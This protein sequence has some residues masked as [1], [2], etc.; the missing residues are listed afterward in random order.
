MTDNRGMT[1]TFV[2]LGANL[3]DPRAQ[4][5]RALEL[6]AEEDGVE[7]VAVSTLRETDP[8]GYED[9]PRFLNGAAELRTTLGARE[10]LER[11]LEI[12]RRMGRVRGE[13]PR[14]GP[15]TIDLDLL[16]YGDEV[17]D[18]PGLEI[19]HPRLH[20]RAFA[21]EPLAELD[22][23]LEIPGRGPVQTLLAGL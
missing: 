21:L 2:G 4:I 15:R 12:E 6:L 14:F 19:P 13:G 8:V 5:D 17:I 11:L 7:V 20:E 3:E 10:L 22:P 9:Q 18:E 23:A 16:L 1:R